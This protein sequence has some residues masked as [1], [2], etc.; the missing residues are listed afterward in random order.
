MW[1]RV[2]ARVRP[3]VR[4][5]FQTCTQGTHFFHSPHNR[6][7]KSGYETP[8]VYP[9]IAIAIAILIAIDISEPFNPLSIVIKTSRAKRLYANY[10][11]R[12]SWPR[13]LQRQVSIMTLMCHMWKTMSVCVMVHLLNPETTSNCFEAL[14][15]IFETRVRIGMLRASIHGNGGMLNYGA[16]RKG[17]ASANDD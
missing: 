16:I 17:E 3:V 5:P 11:H 1:V 12:E 14:E 9:P 15:S 10:I 4:K 2:L 13:I 8:N 7:Q 6:V